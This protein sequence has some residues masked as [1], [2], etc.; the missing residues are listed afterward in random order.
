MTLEIRPAS[1]G[2]APAIARVRIDGWRTAYRGLVPDASLDA[3]D[4]DASVT[5]WQRILAAGPNTTSVFVADDN[6]EVVGFAAANM[7]EEP[8]HDLDAELSAVY[9]RRDR[10][11]TGVGRRLVSAVARAQRGHGASGLIAWTLAGNKA[12]RAFLEAL[13]ATLVTEQPFEWDG[14]QL[15]EAGYGFA[16]LDALAAAS[17]APTATQGPARASKMVH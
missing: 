3:M 17:E 14:L 4:V 5:L 10:Q 12:A 2:D 9:V 1:V 15:T 6:G 13:G 16:D 7:L 11:H 8:R